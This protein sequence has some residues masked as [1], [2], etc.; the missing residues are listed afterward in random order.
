MTMTEVAD[1]VHRFS[2]AYVNFYVVEGREGLTLV[3]SGLPAM[4]T[5]LERALQGQ[6][7]SLQDIRALHRAAAEACR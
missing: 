4:W 5:P 2:D 6:G 1:G 3:D 7:F